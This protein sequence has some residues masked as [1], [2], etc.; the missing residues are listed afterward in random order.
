MKPSNNPNAARGKPSATPTHP[1]GLKTPRTSA[2]RGPRFEVNR[3]DGTRETYIPLTYLAEAWSLDYRTLRNFV[4]DE[5]GIPTENQ[6][7]YH[8]F[9]DRP[10]DFIVIREA[11]LL[12]LYRCLRCLSVAGAGRSVS[13]PAASD[14]PGAGGVR[15]G[16]GEARTQP[17]APEEPH[18]EGT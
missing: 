17:P 3:L 2:Y 7:F 9:P 4:R 14:S 5:T 1:P 15:N 13:P 8:D 6:A 11:D 10:T 18:G 16:S 12:R